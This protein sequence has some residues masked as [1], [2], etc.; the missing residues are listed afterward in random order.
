MSETERGDFKLKFETA[1]L[2]STD[3]VHQL[4]SLRGKEREQSGAEES[5]AEGN[6]E[7]SVSHRG[8][9]HTHK[10]LVLWSI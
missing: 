7:H 3:S 9:R 4:L 1:D 5:A 10:S 6:G 8:Q 2:S